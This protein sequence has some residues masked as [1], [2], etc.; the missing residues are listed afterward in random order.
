MKIV[1]YVGRTDF[2]QNMSFVEDGEPIGSIFSVEVETKDMTKIERA[3]LLPFIDLN[4]ANFHV[5][6]QTQGSENRYLEFSGV[7]S[8]STMLSLLAAEY[9]KAGKMPVRYAKVT[10]EKQ[11]NNF[12]TLYEGGLY[13]TAVYLMDKVTGKNG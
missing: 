1:F 3:M 2:W 4:W 9:K 8:V 6:V 13:M 11:A 12:W 10:D 5:H 7:P